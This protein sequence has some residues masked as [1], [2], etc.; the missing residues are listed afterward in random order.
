MIISGKVIYGDRYGK[1]L[2]FPTANLDRREYSRRKLKIRFGVYTGWAEILPPRPP[3]VDTPPKIGGKK[4]G[5]LT[6]L[7][8]SGGAGGGRCT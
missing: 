2:G 7:L 1:R 4:M 6:P 8:L 3:K 5:C